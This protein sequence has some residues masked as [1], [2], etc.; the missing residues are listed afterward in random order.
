MTEFDL[1]ILVPE[2]QFFSGKVESIM[3][4]AYDGIM[5]ILSDHKP[6][7]IAIIA[8]QIK[9]KKEGK[10]LLCA[11]S[12][13][14]VRIDDDHKVYVICQTAEWPEDLSIVRVKK[15][16]SEHTKILSYSNNRA[17]RLESE[18]T[19]KRALARLELINTTTGT[20]G[21]DYGD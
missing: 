2:R 8:S 11:N 9:I 12:D 6:A 13:G 4:E 5:E 7:V 16:I 10:E 17:E 18:R 14:I 15:A 21:E 1:E 3:V 20:K 19:L